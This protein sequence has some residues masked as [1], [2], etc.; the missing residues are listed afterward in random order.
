MVVTVRNTWGRSDVSLLDVA[1]LRAMVRTW[2]VPTYG[3]IE[4]T[5]QRFR[6]IKTLLDAQGRGADTF[7]RFGDPSGDTARETSLR[8]TVLHPAGP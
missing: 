6:L 3:S 2:I 8:Y 4:D 5:L 1:T 7:L